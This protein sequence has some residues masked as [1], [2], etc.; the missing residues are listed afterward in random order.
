[1]NPSDSFSALS[2]SWKLSLWADRAA[3]S[4][5]IKCL[6]PL[7]ISIGRTLVYILKR[8]GA[9]TLPCSR[10]FFCILLLFLFLLSSIQYRLFKRRVFID[11]ASLLSLVRA[12]IFKISNLWVPPL[13]LQILLQYYLFFKKN[14]IS[15]LS[16]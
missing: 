6:I 3:S 5:Y 8:V 11:L 12:L 1:M 4:A 15:Q 16:S 13:G 10:P 9:S 14:L 2:T 7:C